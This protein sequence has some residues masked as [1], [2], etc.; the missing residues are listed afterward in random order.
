MS[1]TD[2]AS[3]PK[4]KATMT[5]PKVAL[6]CPYRMHV[7]VP[8]ADGTLPDCGCGRQHMVFGQSY[9]LVICNN[10]ALT[11]LPSCVEQQSNYRYC[12]CGLSASQPFCDDSHI[13]TKFEPL[14]FVCDK[15]QTYYLL[16][17]WYGTTRMVSATYFGIVI[18]LQQTHT[19]RTGLRRATHTSVC[20]RF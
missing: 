16:C 20:E 12:T 9:R 13:G 10:A 1:A 14:S 17:G 15:K 7:L 3:A 4:D 5:Q 2:K 18:L 8:Q 11:I 6:S 19:I